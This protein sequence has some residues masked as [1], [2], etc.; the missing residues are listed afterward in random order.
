M[1]VIFGETSL[2]ELIQ[3]RFGLKTV[4]KASHILFKI[5]HID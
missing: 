5:F 1:Q 2:L 4:F 3:I